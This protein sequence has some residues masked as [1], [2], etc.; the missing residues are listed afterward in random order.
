M[1]IQPRKGGTQQ[2]LMSDSTCSDLV[3]DI[4]GV[5][6]IEPTCL[7]EVAKPLCTWS[8]PLL[9]PAPTYSPA[10]DAVQCWQHVTYGKHDWPLPPVLSK[11]EDVEVCT[12]VFATA[13]LEGNVLPVFQG[14][15]SDSTQSTVSIIKTCC[16]RK[17]SLSQ[18][19]C[20]WD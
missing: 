5:T 13:L 16:C 8:G 10:A 15:L 18:Y 9:E 12:A 11:H 3:F 2:Q 4:A 19:D 6:A 7:S 20:A 1:W 14:E 17:Q